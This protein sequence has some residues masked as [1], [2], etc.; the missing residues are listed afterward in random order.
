MLSL[1]I[2]IF[3]ALV[4]DA[5]DTTFW[6]AEDAA[7]RL[8]LDV[9]AAIPGARH[10]PHVSRPEDVIRKPFDPSRRRSA[11]IAARYGQAIRGLRNALSTATLERPARSVLIT[12][13]N[14]S[15]GK[16]TTAINLAVASA[17]IGKKVLLL[18]ADLR[19][20]T[21]HKHFD[22]SPATGLSDVLAG[23]LPIRDVIVKIDDLNLHVM[24]S[25]R[26]SRHAADLLSMGFASTLESVTRDFDL[27][28]V[29]GPPMLGIA[30]S[31]EMAGL[32]DGVLLLTKAGTTT[33]RAVAETLA[34]LTRVR[35]N[36]LGVV[37]NQVK[38]SNC[39]GP[40]YYSN[41]VPEKA[42]AKT[43]HA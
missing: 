23:T 6:D 20:P 2:G 3:S 14:P 33:S 1:L 43:A 9:L 11:E 27:V 26:I 31:Q 41:P 13:P 40:Y 18:D 42:K 22:L 37:M 30:E 38:L 16:S 4:R 7:N 34:S 28:I 5:M 12:S 35:A 8:R 32:V 25:G 39:Y 36:I 17:Q 29:D 21:L 24:P 19:R 10:L 15:E